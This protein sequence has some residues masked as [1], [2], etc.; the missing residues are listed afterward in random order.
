M[1]PLFAFFKCLDILDCV[2]NLLRIFL[3]SS[4]KLMSLNERNKKRG[5]GRAEKQ[6][7]EKKRV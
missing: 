1:F 3:C 7:W 4:E 5:G 6:E 2:D